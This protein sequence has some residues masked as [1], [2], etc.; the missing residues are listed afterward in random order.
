MGRAVGGGCC[1]M[2]AEDGDQGGTHGT[3]ADLIGA[4]GWVLLIGLVVGTYSS[5]FTAAPVAIRLHHR[6]P[7]GKPS[8]RA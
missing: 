1:G 7:R 8:R 3:A 5:V 6:F 4:Q 2:D